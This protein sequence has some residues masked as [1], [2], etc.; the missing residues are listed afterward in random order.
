MLYS[1]GTGGV[2]ISKVCCCLC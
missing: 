1:Q 2:M